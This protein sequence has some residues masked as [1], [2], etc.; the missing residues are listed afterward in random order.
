V[1]RHRVRARAFT[2][3][4]RD[5]GPI[6]SS[7]RV[8]RV[9]RPRQALGAA[10]GTAG[11]AF[12]SSQSS[13]DTDSARAAALLR[14]AAPGS[15]GDTGRVVW[16]IPGGAVTALPPGE[17][18]VMTL[19]AKGLA[20]KEIAERLFFT[21]VTAKTH[22]N[23]AMTKLSARDRAQLVVIAYETGLVRAGERQI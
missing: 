4:S 13:Q 22:T 8:R 14:T 11:P 12:S 9:L 1:G 17:R 5:L 10:I 18:E 3:R 19:V 16:Q 15:A 23:R 21:E 20:N 7:P 2:R 6:L